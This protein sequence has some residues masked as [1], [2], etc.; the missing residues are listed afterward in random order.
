M[1]D[2]E[3]RF[4]SLSRAPA[5]D[6]WDDARER[7][8]RSLPAQP[9]APRIATMIVA[10]S[11][12]TA[13]IG[14]GLI[15]LAGGLSD[16][17]A[18]VP[19]EGRIAFV[20]PGG[21]TWQLYSVNA[22]GT[23]LQQLTHVSSPSLA[24]NPVWSPDGT[25]I[26]YT[27]RISDTDSADMWV[28]NADG[29]DAHAIAQGMH[30][31]GLTWSPDG[32]KIAFSG[33]KPETANRIWIV[34]TDGYN[35]H[36]LTL[37]E[38]P[39]C[40]EDSSPAWSPDGRTV[41]YVRRSGAGAVAPYSIFLMPTDRDADLATIPL[42]DAT[43]ATDLV[44]SPDGSTLAFTMTRGAETGIFTIAGDGSGLRHLDAPPSAQAPAWSPYGGRIAFQGYAPGTVRDT[45]Y[46]MDADGSRVRQIS[47]LPR[48]AISPTWTVSPSMTPTP[49]PGALASNGAIAYSMDGEL[50]TIEPDGT[51]AR[52]IDVEAG[53]GGI[54]WAPDGR[55]LAFDLAN[56]GEGSC[57][58]DVFTA[59]ADGSDVVR[60]TNDGWSRLPAW[61]PDGGRIAYSDQRDGGSQ[62]VLM[63]TD[64][65]DAR[66]VTRGSGFSLRPAWSPDGSKIAFESVMNR[67][68][69]IYVMD[70]DGTDPT[71]LTD[72]E[73]GDRSPV[74]APDG[75]QIA[76]TSSREPSGVYVMDADGSNQR[77]VVPDQD[78]DNLGIA[79]SPDGTALALASD[80]GE[81]FGRAIYVFEL[82]SGK[83]TQLTE[84][85]AIWGPAWQPLVPETGPAVVEPSTVEATVTDTI[86]VASYPNAIAV[87]EG[88]VW[89][90]APA[91]DDSGMGE[92]VRIDPDTGEIVAR[93]GP[94]A[95]PTW[96]VGGGGMA[97]GLGSVWVTGNGDAGTGAEVLVQ[98]IDPATDEVADVIP[99]GAGNAADVWA[100]ETG[101][102][103]LYWSGDARTMRV[104]RIDPATLAVTAAGSV[105]AIWSQTIFTGNGSVWVLGTDA[106][107]HGGNFPDTLW[108]L[109]PASLDIVGTTEL[110]DAV[111]IPST[112]PE[113][114][115][116]RT[117][118]GVR[119]VDLASGEPVG[120]PIAPFPGCCTNPFVADGNGGVWYATSGDAG[121]S[122]R[123]VHVDAGGVVDATGQITADDD[124]WGGITYAF[125]PATR[126]I[127][128]LHYR[129]SVTVIRVSVG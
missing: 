72:D 106:T 98:R 20:A 85:G 112:S 101:I 122:S 31:H 97:V 36:T 16:R 61:S 74:W 11:V 40:L 88:S 58:C 91:D 26:A 76:F 69:D 23:D 41:A 48:E 124:V 90:S 116:I 27:L 28:A 89:I 54:S 4:R 83:L 62:I 68:A 71:R 115:W 53:V 119:R 49:S 96:E 3:E 50:W 38:E 73:A 57:R 2:L 51:G 19:D 111:W 59:N 92:V 37:C 70:A 47:G 44:W 82:A 127:W 52:R 39:E 126:T 118:D 10:F 8:P 32:T 120:K 129:H 75:S 55:R 67:N 113:T 24:S 108:R 95:S 21:G 99:L 81:G 94:L 63:R 60:L 6:V 15:V 66:Q 9:R 5:P 64:G 114:M 35:A 79:W 14:G 109:D 93:I 121:E 78:V 30:V 45:L 17:P 22:D 84:R 107:Q 42:D 46:T 12:A 34:R 13:G 102:F 128:V 103:A 77:L 87:G 104:A 25:E 7:T 29:S 18:A 80:R 117:E 56:G 125:E 65:S 110:G 86:R 105:P 1:A 43:Y 123:I 33:A 100:D